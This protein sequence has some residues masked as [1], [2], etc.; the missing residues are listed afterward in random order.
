LA[1][2]YCGSLATLSEHPDIV[3]PA[4][5][6]EAECLRLSCHLFRPEQYAAFAQMVRV[7]QQAAYAGRWPD[8]TEFEALGGELAQRLGWPT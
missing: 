3:L 2:L 7:W 5:A 6:T 4:S 1:L 8:T